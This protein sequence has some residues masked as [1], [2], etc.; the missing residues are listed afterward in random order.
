MIIISSREIYLYVAKCNRDDSKNTFAQCFL[1]AFLLISCY[2]TDI[3]GTGIGRH[4]PI[5]QMRTLRNRKLSGI[6][7]IMGPF[8]S[9]SGTKVL[10][11]QAQALQEVQVKAVRHCKCHLYVHTLGAPSWWE[12]GDMQWYFLT[13]EPADRSIEVKVVWMEGT[14]P[15]GLPHGQ[16]NLT[17]HFLF[18][19]KTYT[20]FPPTLQ[21]TGI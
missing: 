20:G 16:L 9:S 10:S 15:L 6:P 13:C 4:C 8:G 17:S 2:A 1:H 19:L 11:L 12:K 7:A 21:Q 3:L 5:S 14:G 18:L